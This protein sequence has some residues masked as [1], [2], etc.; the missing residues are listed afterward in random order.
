VVA[1]EI[2]LQRAGPGVA[3][4]HLEALLLNG[5]PIPEM[6][7]APLMAEVGAR[8]PALTRTGRDLLVAMP[9]DGR[10]TLLRGGIRV[11]IEPA[12]TPPPRAGAR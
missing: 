12:R 6:L 7:L 2:V 1:A 9:E 10:M 11:A 4:F 8:Y 3:R 5:V